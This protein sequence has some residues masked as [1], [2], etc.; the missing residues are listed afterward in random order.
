MTSVAF[1]FLTNTY[2]ETWLQRTAWNRQL[3]FVIPGLRYNRVNFCTKITN[4]FVITEC[5]ITTEFG[6]TEFHCS[7]IF[8][9]LYLR[10]LCS[11]NFPRIMTKPRI[12]RKWPFKVILTKSSNDT[13]TPKNDVIYGQP[14]K[15]SDIWTDN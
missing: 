7:Y 2:S 15:S 9:R 8:Y 3:L 1:S 11:N 12:M 14:R 13:S 4:Q 5:S 10:G 6:I